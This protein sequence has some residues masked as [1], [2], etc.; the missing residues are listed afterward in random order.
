MNLIS[1]DKAREIILKSG[2]AV[3]TESLVNYYGDLND[4][5]DNI[6]TYESN[7]CVLLNITNSDD[8]QWAIYS[9]ISET[10]IIS[11]LKSNPQLKTASGIT[12]YITGEFPIEIDKRMH[13][14]WQKYRKFGENYSDCSVRKITSEDKELMD[15]F[16]TAPEDDSRYAT[17]EI[18]NLSYEFNESIGEFEIL[19]VFEGNELTGLISIRN[20]ESVDI[21]QLCD[22]YVKKDFR[23]KGY[24]KRLISAACSLYPNKEYFYTVAESNLASI[25]AAKSCGFNYIGTELYNLEKIIE[26]F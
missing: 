15:N 4:Y 13:Q 9:V 2:K 22:L 11:A 3:N 23:Q 12:G 16:L 7:G 8:F 10:D 5:M 20:Y 18:E 25:A 6:L 24:S 26:N 1:K 14:G 19:G 21:V 17:V